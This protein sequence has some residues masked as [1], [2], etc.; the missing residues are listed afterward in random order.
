MSNKTTPTVLQPGSHVQIGDSKVAMV[1]WHEAPAT[2]GTAVVK[3]LTGNVLASIFYAGRNKGPEPRPVTFNPPISA[4]GGVFGFA[5]GGWLQV[6]V[7]GSSE[8][9]H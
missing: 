3:D 2:G 9:G 5:P 7:Q 4:V 6:H 8:S 1:I